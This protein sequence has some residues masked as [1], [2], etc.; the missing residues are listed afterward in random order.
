MD[1]PVRVAQ[2][3]RFQNKSGEYIPGFNFQNFFANE[4]KTY[5]GIEYGFGSF[6]FTGTLGNGAGEGSEA[7]LLGTVN[8]LTVNIFSEAVEKFWLIEIK[9]VVVIFNED[10]G[11]FEQG[12]TVSVETWDCT[13]MPRDNNQ[14]VIRLADP[15]D[16]VQSQAPRR[17][18]TAS[19]VG[20]LPS[21]GNINLQ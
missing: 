12:A 3:V 10:T 5:A 7:N 4:E 13:A 11:A 20:S 14:V 21:T 2:Y 9:R 19:L 6:L 17:R 1:T 18:L 16:A 8:Q 15:F